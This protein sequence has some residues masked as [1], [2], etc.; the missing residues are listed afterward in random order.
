MNKHGRMAVFTEFHFFS[1]INNF[2]S[3]I[4]IAV[5]CLELTVFLIGDL[6]L[7]SW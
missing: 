6:F 1:I 5:N 4:L 7:I 2:I 3:L